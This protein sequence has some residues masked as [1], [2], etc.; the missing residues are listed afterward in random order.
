MGNSVIQVLLGLV[1]MPP[2][3]AGIVY[4]L[5]NAGPYLP[6]ALWGFVFTLGIF[7]MTIYPVAIAPLFNK[8][9]ALEEVS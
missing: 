5:L 7:F 1:L 6:F 9:E 3:T 2:L 4:I 8:F